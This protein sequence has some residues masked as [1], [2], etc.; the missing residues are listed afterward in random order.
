[1]VKY[2]VGQD[3]IDY[4]TDKAQL[5]KRRGRTETQFLMDLDCELH[6]YIMIRE[7]VWDESDDWRVDA[8]TPYRVDVKFI[9]KYYNISPIKMCNILAQRGVL[10]G[11]LF[12]EWIERPNRPLEAGDEVVFRQITYMDY[13]ELLDEI[14]PSRFNGHYADIR[15]FVR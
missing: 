5:Y 7:G 9:Q 12:M 13:E 10:D 15:G 11:Y 4:R 14:K 1:M 8:I 3:F 6:E 2:T